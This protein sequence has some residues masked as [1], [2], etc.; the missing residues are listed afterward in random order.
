MRNKA[1]WWRSIH[2][3][4]GKSLWWIGTHNRKQ[5]VEQNLSIYSCISSQRNMHLAFCD[6]VF[7][8]KTSQMVSCK[9]SIPI[10]RAIWNNLFQLT[11]FSHTGNANTKHFSS[12][13]RNGETKLN[14]HSRCC[15]AVVLPHAFS[16]LFSAT[17]WGELDR[18]AAF[19]KTTGRQVLKYLFISFWVV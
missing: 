10:T 6:S 13:L 3:W 19:S 18:D 16:T 4:Q 12:L 1:L 5:Y 14:M 11:K 2:D 15:H 17:H 8:G 7:L 9:Y